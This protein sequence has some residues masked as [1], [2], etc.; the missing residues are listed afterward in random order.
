MKKLIKLGLLFAL[1][2]ALG[3]LT[4]PV[5]G[6]SLELRGVWVSTVYGLDWPSAPGLS[7]AALQA[8]AETVVKNAKDWGMNAIFLQVRP[9]ADALYVSETEPWSQWLSGVQGQ[10]ADGGFDPLDCY[11]QL[12]RE[13]GLQLHAWINPYR[14]TR[15]AAESREQAFAQLCPEHPARQQAEWVVFHTDGCLYYDP[16][17]PEVRQMLL[18]VAEELLQRYPVDGLH[19]DDY[20]YPGSDFADEETFRNYGGDYESVGDFRRASVTGLVA[21]LGELTHRVR[22]GAVFGVSPAG[23]WATADHDPLGAETRGGQSYYDHYA[24]SRRWVREELVDY[25]IPQIYWEIGAASGEYQT[26]LDWWSGVARDTQVKLYIGLAAYKSAQAEEGSLWYGSDEL[27]RQLS[28]IRLSDV[29]CGAVLFR[30]GSVLGQPAEEGVRQA[31]S[32]ETGAVPAA[33][34]KPVYAGDYGDCAVLSGARAALHYA[35]PAR[36]QV[37]AFWGSGWARLR[38]DGQGGYTGSIPA[39]VPYNCESVTHPVLF[40][41]QRNGVVSVELSAFTLTAVRPE[42]RAEVRSVT[43]QETAGGH[44]LSFALS[45]P[46]AAAVRCSGDVLQVSLQPCGGEPV[47]VQDSWLR[48]SSALRQEETLFWRLVLPDTGGSWQARLQWEERRLV[49]TVTEAPGTL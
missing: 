11:L 9:C 5:H 46:C 14:I 27:L 16:G 21:A 25:I 34:A 3:A 28:R 13:A 4:L 33:A 30:Y 35:A 38:S 7:A 43:G 42:Q 37:T 12:C 31:F 17:R 26:M 41:T 44:Q 15:K 45:G 2:C 48:H 39:E 40:C 1:L 47:L 29:A 36:S 19:L 10:A 8:E 6:A 24:D 49:I 22:P 32:Q 23:I 18:S 20:F